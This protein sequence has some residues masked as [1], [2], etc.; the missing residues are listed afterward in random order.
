MQQLVYNI[1]AFKRAIR[2]SFFAS[3]YFL[4]LVKALPAVALYKPK[5]LGF[6]LQKAATAIPNATLTCLQI[7][8]LNYL[9]LKQI[10]HGVI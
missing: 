2:S 8:V 5:K 6:Q 3:S 1:R 10:T 9:M 4:W 7:L